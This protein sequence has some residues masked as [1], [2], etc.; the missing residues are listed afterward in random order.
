MPTTSGI[1]RINRPHRL[2]HGN[3]AGG[4]HPLPDERRIWIQ[5]STIVQAD[6]WVGGTVIKRDIIFGVF[7]EQRSLRI[8]QKVGVELVSATDTTLA[9]TPIIT[10]N[11]IAIIG[12]RWEQIMIVVSVHH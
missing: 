7:R 6:S 11:L 4:S 2:T 1:S 8:L 5:S 12:I 10:W 3:T 9:C